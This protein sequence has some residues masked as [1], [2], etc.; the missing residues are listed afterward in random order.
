MSHLRHVQCF[1]VRYSEIDQMGTYY[2][3]RALEWFEW[4]RTELCRTLGKS[5]HQWE[6][7]G[8]RLPVV[9]AHVE[10]LGKAQYDDQL[11]MTTIAA[12]AGRARMRFDVLVE[13]AQTGAPV[14]QGYT[15][16][17]ITDLAG[18]PIRPPAWMRELMAPA[19]D[20]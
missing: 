20:T 14:C 13:N 16:H 10:Y 1:R 2:N 7:D 11:Q 18:K 17:A 5:Y 9:T 12:M 3:A 15:I 6:Q 8:V 4:G 19:A